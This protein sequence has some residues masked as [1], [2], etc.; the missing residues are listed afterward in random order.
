MVIHAYLNSILYQCLGIIV[1]HRHKCMFNMIKIIRNHY[2]LA[3]LDILY[4]RP[5]V[6]VE[7]DSGWPKSPF[8]TI[9]LLM[10]NLG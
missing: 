1:H 8:D 2:L 5:K 3:I 10:Q 7:G 4:R 9:L 6:H